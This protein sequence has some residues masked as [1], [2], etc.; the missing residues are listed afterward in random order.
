MVDRLSLVIY[1]TCVHCTY[2]Y[3][4]ISLFTQPSHPHRMSTEDLSRFTLD[5]GVGGRSE[6]LQRKAIHRIYGDKAADIV[7]GLVK[8]P[9]VAVPVVLKR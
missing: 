6:I 3:V 9:N 5:S 8:N 4:N 7:D 2:T 1:V